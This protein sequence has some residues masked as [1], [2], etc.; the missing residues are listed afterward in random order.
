MSIKHVFGVLALYLLTSALIYAQGNLPPVGADWDGTFT[1]GIAAVVNKDLITVDELRG[2]LAPL[3]PELRRKAVTEVEFNQLLEELSFE[4]LRNLI[5]RSLIVKDFEDQGMSIPKVFLEKEYDD[6]ITEEF[7]SDRA[8]FIQ[9]LKSESKTPREFRNTLRNKM[10]VDYMRN[11]MRK[12]ESSVS[13]AKII[14]YYEKNKNV[15]F[16][17][18]EGIHLH[19]IM[20]AP[21]ANESTELLTQEADKI[22][23]QLHKGLSFAD[24]AR[25]HSQ[26]D[27]ASKGG[28]YGWISRS[29]LAPELAKVAFRLRENEY[30]EPVAKDG[31]VFI[32]Y[33]EERRHD[34]IQPLNKV[35]AKI[36]EVLAAEAARKARKLWLERLRENAYIRYYL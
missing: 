36:E 21:I 32:F 24:M 28:D 1:N 9:W 33:V 18:K 35:Q 26:D 8:A 12:S 23:N 11:R 22:L 5:N 6:Y 14:Q 2:E 13:P 27:L 34:G 30:S 31:Y 15:L 20:L 3:V 10:I 4:V 7:N 25:E 16:Y 19:Q 29:D 17:E